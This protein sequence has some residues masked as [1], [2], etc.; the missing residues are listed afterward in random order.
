MPDFKNFMWQ[1]MGGTPWNSE[2]KHDW[3]IHKGILQLLI[4][5]YSSSYYEVDAATLQC[6]GSE[7]AGMHIETCFA[8]HDFCVV[9]PTARPLLAGQGLT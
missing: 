5:G 8:R 2:C 1:E 4:W 3:I 7:N 6:K 9:S